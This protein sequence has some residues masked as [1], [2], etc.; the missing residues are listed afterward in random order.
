MKKQKLPQFELSKEGEINNIAFDYD[1]N[2]EKEQC[3]QTTFTMKVSNLC[4]EETRKMYEK[5][6]NSGESI[7][8]HVDK[9]GNL[10][11]FKNE[12]NEK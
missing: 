6:W 9:D 3:Y 5:L 11:Q 7:V 12:T 2:T 10:K 1:E 8:I 4:L